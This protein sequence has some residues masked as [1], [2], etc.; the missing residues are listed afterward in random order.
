MEIAFVC[1]LRRLRVNHA[2]FLYLEPLRE[3]LGILVGRDYYLLRPCV[4]FKN[5]HFIIVRSEPP[6]RRNHFSRE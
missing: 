2:C 1:D 3:R 6:S 4:R 5:Q